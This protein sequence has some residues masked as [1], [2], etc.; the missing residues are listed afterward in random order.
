[1]K[2]FVT[3][4]INCT[5]DGHRVLGSD[6]IEVQSLFYSFTGFFSWLLIRRQR[7]CCTSV[8]KRNPAPG[9]SLFAPCLGITL[10]LAHWS[11]K[12]NYTTQ[13]RWEVMYVN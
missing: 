7:W 10:A 11:M 5:W 12:R 2:Q 6:R 13:S 1:M 3:S 4:S 9:V 8:E